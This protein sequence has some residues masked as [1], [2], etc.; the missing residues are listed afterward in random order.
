MSSEEHGAEDRQ[1]LPRKGIQSIE[2][3]VRLLD[4]LIES[5]QPMR[6]RELSKLSGLSPSKAR[7]YLVSFI[8]TGLITQDEGGGVYQPGPKALRLGL[9][10]LGQSKTIGSAREFVYSFG[11]ETGYPVLLTVWDEMSPVIVESSENKDTLPIVFRIGTRT[12]LWTTATGEV[13]LAYLPEQTV[14][15]AIA[16]DCP[17]SRDQ[18]HRTGERVRRERYAYAESVRITTTATLSG[19]GALAVPVLS[20]DGRLESVITALVPSQADS[21]A[22]G[23]MANRMLERISHFSQVPS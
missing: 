23:H 22:P 3:G 14:E 20:T 2:T 4:V 9:V 18:V 5:R 6:L 15:K 8:R 1:V 16:A 10:A 17:L 21:T 13:F 12:P 11:R 19:Y 7:M